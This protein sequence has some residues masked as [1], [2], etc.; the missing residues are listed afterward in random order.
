MKKILISFLA[1][2]LVCQAYPQ[3]DIQLEDLQMPASPAFVLLDV[4]PSSI[5]RPTTIKAFTTSL[6]NNITE[7]NGIPENYAVDFAPYWFFRHKNLTAMKYWGFNHIGDQYRETPFSQMRYGSLS[8]ASVRSQIPVDTL[9]ELQYV[10]NIAFGFRTCLFQIR[11]ASAIDELVKLNKKYKDRL[12]EIA[13]NPLIPG[14]EL[15]NV[16]AGDE[17]LLNTINDIRSVLARKPVFAIDLA[18]SG[19]WSFGNSDFNSISINRYGLWLILS[20][21]QSLNKKEKTIKENY[22][23]LYATTRIL[24]DHKFL[25]EEG[26]ISTVQ[27]MDAGGKAELELGRFS[28]AYEYLARLNLTNSGQ[29]SF[30]SSGTISYRASEQFLITAAFGKNF[31]SLN[32]LIS[33]IGIQWGLTGKNQ[34]VTF[35]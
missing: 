6:V 14:S 17:D 1:G 26:N 16:I 34:E 8:M 24:S 30:R 27:M 5:E 25:N 7:T 13:D 15:A 32:N 21:S 10:N 18:A 31:G 4:A 12:K 35:D 23:S 22:L 11:G 33:Q 19:A 28:I 20:Y 2:I 9:A 3:G 29:Q